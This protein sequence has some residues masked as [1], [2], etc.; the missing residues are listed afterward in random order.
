MKPFKISWWKKALSYLF[1]VPIH[2]TS[3]EVNELLSVSLVRNRL[4]L[5]TAKSIY[6][7]DDLY[8]NFF[9]A[10]ELIKLPKPDTEIL[11]LGLGLGSIPYM[12]EKN[13]NR[14]YRY[15]AV[16]LDESVIDL[17]SK[18][19]LNRLISPIQIIHT[20]AE[21][22][23]KTHQSK[24]A[25]ILVDLFIEDLVPSFFESKQG[26]ELLKKMLQAKGTVLFNRLYRTGRDKK[27]T[28]DFYHKVFRRVFN[29]PDYLEVDGNRILVGRE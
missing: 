6:S 23:I 22:F 13:F 17:A 24:Y 5:S 12:L 9:R 25:L 29:D 27:S 4:Q 18:F 14:K 1:E 7:F 20:D 15:I 28:D 19:S 8:S 21:L 16:E 11:I 2:T 26:N 10:F 3:S